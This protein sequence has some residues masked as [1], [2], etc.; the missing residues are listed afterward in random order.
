MDNRSARLLLLPPLLRDLSPRCRFEHDLHP[1]EP[2]D[3]FI[4]FKNY[5]SADRS[6]APE[7]NLTS[8]APLEHYD[9]AIGRARG[10]P[11]DLISD[12]G[13]FSGP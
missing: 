6:D 12:V 1:A 9:I 2:V 5:G 4:T 8:T 11:L 13:E 10:A 3:A 7:A